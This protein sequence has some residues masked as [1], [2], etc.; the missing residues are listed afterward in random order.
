MSILEDL[1]NEMKTDDTVD[2]I[3]ILCDRILQEENAKMPWIDFRPM[4]ANIFIALQVPGPTKQHVGFLSLERETEDLYLGVFWS[5][6]EKD[7]NDAVEQGQLEDSD[8]TKIARPR[9]IK[10]HDIND[11]R[12]EKILTAYAKLIKFYHGE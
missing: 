8:P 5:I 6:F 10:V 4:G 7:L 1:I 3:R 9:K 12:P 11:H 2:K